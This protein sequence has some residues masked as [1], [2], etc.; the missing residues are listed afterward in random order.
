MTA[1]SPTRRPTQV[2]VALLLVLAFLPVADRSLFEPDEGR[3]AEIGRTMLR[4]G[5]WL[6]PRFG[7]ELH[8]T[9]PPFA[10]WMAAAGTAAFGANEV[11]ARA[12]A[13][14][15]GFLTGLVVIG[16]GRRL[17]GPEAGWLAGLIYA[18][19]PMSF[20]ASHFLSTD[21]FIVFWQALGAFAA[22]SAWQQP[23]RA[24][25]WRWLFWVA[26]GLSFMTK[27][28]PGILG[29]LPIAV[30]AGHR[31]RRGEPAVLWSWGGLA[32]FLLLGF[33]WFGVMVWRDPALVK[34]F[35]VDE[36]IN[37]VAT[38]QHRRETTRIIYAAAF[39]VGILPWVWL[40]GPLW[41]R[42]QAWWRGRPRS[43]R[44]PWLFLAT[45]IVPGVA[46]FC[47]SRSRL[48]L[49]VAPL[50]V[51]LAVALGRALEPRAGRVLRP[52]PAVALALWCGIILLLHHITPT[53]FT[54]GE[55]AK[56][57]ASTVARRSDAPTATLFLATGRDIGSLT[58]Y[59]DG[60]GAV[61]KLSRHEI[62]A[63]TTPAELRACG[64]R[65][66]PGGGT[67]WLVARHKDRREISRHSGFLEPVLE[68]AD[69]VLFR[70]QDPTPG[71]PAPSPP[72]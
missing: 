46:V 40:Y 69:L 42:F 8:L 60:V 15:F 36:T 23:A 50:M 55:S 6:L 27:G 48:L 29:L 49:Y 26:F 59:A 70:V 62:L 72:R 17:F 18:T 47:L 68:T 66:P 57:I 30:V 11:G 5:D 3:Y 41:M 13:V 21:V 12:G 56:R 63:A 35:L 14:L 71:D 43:V 25:R 20:G 22:V 34:Y 64:L 28:P 31:R 54:L 51:P 1:A 37:R 16:I 67:S 61:H 45:W 58:Y 52:L 9:K 32:A 44:W 10:Y 53:Q 19:S 38:G 65:P 33:W 39:T 2:V 7:S 24:K 4:S